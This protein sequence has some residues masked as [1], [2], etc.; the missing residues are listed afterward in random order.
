MAFISIL[1][2]VKM[3]LDFIP[4]TPQICLEVIAAELVRKDFRQEQS[5][6]DGLFSPPQ[7]LASQLFL[8][9][10]VVMQVYL[11]PLAPLLIVLRLG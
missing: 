6:D 5:Q 4:S 8:V 2:L 7:S 1:P 3:V 11:R 10:E 9:V